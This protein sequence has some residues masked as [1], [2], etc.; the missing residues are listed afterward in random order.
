MEC[1]F[2][3]RSALRRS[4][5]DW[6]VSD[7]A[8]PQDARVIYSLQAKIVA[9]SPKI[10][11]SDVKHHSESKTIL[12]IMDL[13]VQKKR[14]PQK[15]TVQYFGS[16]PYSLSGYIFSSADC[17][18]IARINVNDQISSSCTHLLS[19]K[20]T[21]M[22]MPLALQNS[23]ITSFVFCFSSEFSTKK[24]H[25]FDNLSLNCINKSSAYF[26]ITYHT[27]TIP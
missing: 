13:T 24:L 9:I 3:R 26:V 14:R 19:S 1:F 20:L 2:T 27:I 16:Y 25:S 17:V 5:Y 10:V 21:H 6:L 23:Q 18:L 12:N 11:E 22:K 7:E 4:N 15:L 8:L